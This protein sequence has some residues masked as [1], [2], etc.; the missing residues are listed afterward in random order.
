LWAVLFGL[1]FLLTVRPSHHAWLQKLIYLGS[2]I[3]GMMIIYLSQQRALLVVVAIWFAAMLAILLWRQRWR[4]GALLAGLVLVLALGSF[5]VAA[6][7]GGND[8][9]QRVTSLG[10]GQG[11]RVYRQERG[12]FLAQAFGPFLHQYPLGAGLGRWGMMNQ[13]FGDNSDPQTGSLYVEIQWQAWVLDGGAPLLAAYVVLLLLTGWSLFR[14]ARRRQ[15]LWLWAALCLAY[16]VG[17]VALTFDYTP[18]T[19]QMG[20]EFWF[21]NA[22]VLTAVAASARESPRAAHG[23]GR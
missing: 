7:V 5:R 17:I 20:L 10:G 23:G 8:M 22:L 11:E 19:G 6:G 14:L 4:E 2:M 15:R 18:F 21:L 1:G 9:I 3:V 12:T 16:D 13:Y